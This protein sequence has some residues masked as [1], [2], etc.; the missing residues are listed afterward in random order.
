MQQAFSTT[1][2]QTPVVEPLTQVAR[3]IAELE[4]RLK[5]ATVVPKLPWQNLV[6]LVAAT[7]GPDTVLLRL[8]ARESNLRLGGLAGNYA[9]LENLRSRLEGSGLFA[10]V[11]TVESRQGDDGITFSLEAPWKK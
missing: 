1:F 8:T 10:R 4:K 11:T 7:A 3:S 2:P 5:E 9:A 6:K